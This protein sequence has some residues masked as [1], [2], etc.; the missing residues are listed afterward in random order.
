MPL[1]GTYFVG[2]CTLAHASRT[3]G[4]LDALDGRFDDCPPGPTC[5]ELQGVSM[6]LMVCGRRRIRR[7]QGSRELRGVAMPWM[8]AG[9]EHDQEARCVENS[10]ASRCALDS[11]VRPGG[12]SRT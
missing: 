11:I 9:D 2:A 4:R 3:L 8:G 12:W 7:P 10:R 6:P 5:R 1:M